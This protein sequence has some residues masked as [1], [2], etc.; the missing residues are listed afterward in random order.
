MHT[1]SR[2]GDLSIICCKCFAN[3]TDSVATLICSVASSSGSPAALLRATNDSNRRSCEVIFASTVA[4]ELCRC[5]STA[6]TA[7]VTASLASRATST[8]RWTSV[9]P[10]SPEADALC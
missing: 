8:Y 2:S 10:E 7:R 5:E 9:K 3:D 4:T 1:S 6:E